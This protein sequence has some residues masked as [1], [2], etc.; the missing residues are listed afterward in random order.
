MTVRKVN[1][2]LDSDVWRQLSDDF[3]IG[4][5]CCDQTDVWYM[6]GTFLCSFHSVQ[7]GEAYFS[8]KVSILTVAS[9]TFEERPLSVELKV[10]YQEEIEDILFVGTCFSSY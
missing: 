5:I 9:F 10:C 7:H 2:H 3:Q 8:T 4:I 6:L 1:V